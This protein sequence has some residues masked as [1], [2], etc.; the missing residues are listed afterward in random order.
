MRTNPE[1]AFLKLGL[2]DFPPFSSAALL[3][4]HQVIAQRRHGRIEAMR[5]HAGDVFIVFFD[6]QRVGVEPCL[7]HHSLRQ[8]LRLHHVEFKIV[9]NL[10]Q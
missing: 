10:G 6:V 4:P 9:H 1:S 3:A 2:K 5:A 8:R 7:L